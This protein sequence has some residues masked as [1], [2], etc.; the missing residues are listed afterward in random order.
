MDSKSDKAASGLLFKE[1]DGL[2]LSGLVVS[3]DTVTKVWEGQSYQ[4]LKAG[5]SNGKMSFFYTVTDKNGPLPE[6][7]LGKRA[8]VEVESV[9]QDKGTTTVYGKFSHE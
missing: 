2:F 7:H 3:V 1:R 5:I 8:F 4:Q 9:R 6:V